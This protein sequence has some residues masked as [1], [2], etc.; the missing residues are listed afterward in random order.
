M[1]I[2]IKI[3]SSQHTL[4]DAQLEW[5]CTVRVAGLRCLIAIQLH[6]ETDIPTCFSRVV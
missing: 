4:F 1:Y 2:Q 5:S 3:T 6:Q